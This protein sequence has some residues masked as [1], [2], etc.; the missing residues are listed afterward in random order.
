MLH[1]LLVPSDCEWNE[2]T[3]DRHP[4]GKNVA[5][6]KPKGEIFRWA[7]YYTPLVFHLCTA[8]VQVCSLARP[9][10]YECISIPSPIS[11]ISPNLRLHFTRPPAALLIE[12][13]PPERNHFFIQ[14]I[15]RP[16]LS[17]FR[18][19]FDELFELINTLEAGWAR[20][21]YTIKGK[22]NVNR[23]FFSSKMFLWSGRRIWDT[24]M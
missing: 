16:L 24:V 23:V 20:G 10:G 4:N 6:R 19:L 15:F 13:I 3:C 8:A 2:L 1:I 21:S 17:P 11:P 5:S 18:S 14:I 12:A 22:S 7:D 9:S